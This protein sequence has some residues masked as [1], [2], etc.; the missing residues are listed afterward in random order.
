MFDPRN[1]SNPLHILEL[2]EKLQ[3]NRQRRQA[4]IVKT[5]TAAVEDRIIA[6]TAAIKDLLKLGSTRSEISRHLKM[7]PCIVDMEVSRIEAEAKRD[8]KI[9]GYWSNGW[10]GWR[11]YYLPEM[12]AKELDPNL[13]PRQQVVKAYEDVGQEYEMTIQDRVY[14]THWLPLVTA[15]PIKNQDRTKDK[16]A[17]QS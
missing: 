2:H 6:R 5:R 8:K 3:E 13:F 12:K 1:M 9:F 11:L 15:D 16:P 17:L 14:Q 7:H 10:R 4:G